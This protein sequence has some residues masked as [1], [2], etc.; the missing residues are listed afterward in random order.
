MFCQIR[1]ACKRTAQVCKLSSSWSQPLYPIYIQT[2]HIQFLAEN[3]F[4]L[5]RPAALPKSQTISYKQ[6]LAG[7]PLL[8]VPTESPLQSKFI[9]KIQ[10]RRSPPN[11]LSWVQLM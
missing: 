1:S 10:L 2:L 7:I 3:A 9:I 5:E 8:S 4:Q 11:K 6:F